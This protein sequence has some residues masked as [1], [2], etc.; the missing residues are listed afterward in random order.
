VV[1][2]SSAFFDW[3]S[4][5]GT[6]R[7]GDGTSL[8][9][10]Q[11]PAASGAVALYNVST[12]PNAAGVYAVAAG[13]G[14]VFVSN[15]GG[16]NWYQSGLLG[17]NPSNPNQ[18]IGRVASVAFDP[19]DPTGTRIWAGAGGVTI[20]DTAKPSTDPGV[21]ATA[22]F[23]H[24]FYS[25]D[26]GST[27]QPRPGSAGHQLPNVPVRVVQVDPGDPATIYVGTILGL[28]RSVDA[29]QTFDRF[30]SG[31]PMVE[32]TDLC[33]APATAQT[34]GSIKISTYG[35]G[36]WEL[37][38]G[39]GGAASG[40]RGHGDLDF[41]QRLDAF[42]LIDLVAAMGNTWATDGYR[43]EADLTGSTNQIDDADLA[44]FLQ[45]AGGAP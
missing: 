34:A 10:F 17:T 18:W 25:S 19:S 2:R 32:V 38:L 6:I 33:I 13:S 8:G 15:D 1:W 11:S 4:I 9:S 14:V 5:N 7:K 41:N 22:G 28:Y 27:W 40:A 23:S 29:G 43:P 35:R 20:F 3:G 16:A 24:L 39:P 26:R 42:D 45:G 30:G 37:D 21:D 36:F 12:H 44:V 31:L